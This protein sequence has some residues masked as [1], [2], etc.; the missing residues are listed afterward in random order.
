ML[1]RAY[2]KTWFG[3]RLAGWVDE[4]GD[5]YRADWPSGP[6]KQPGWS[7]DEQGYVY[8]E[9]GEYRGVI[10][11]MD[12]GGAVYAQYGRASS[13]FFNYP[14]SVGFFQP[15]KTFSPALAFH[16][17]SNGRVFHQGKLGVKIIGHIEGASNLSEVAGLALVVLL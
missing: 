4:H 14:D 7:V 11:W 12:D 9:A 10:G 3:E 2:R 13:G 16:V 17:S 5:T 6:T 8:I 15:R 1:M